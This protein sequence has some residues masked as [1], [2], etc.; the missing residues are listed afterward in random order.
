MRCK[1]K[2]PRISRVAGTKYIRIAERPTFFRPETFIESPAR[3]RII[4]RAILLSSEE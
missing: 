1:K 4:I 3:M 2:Y